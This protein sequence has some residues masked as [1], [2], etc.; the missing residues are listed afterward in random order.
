[1]ASHLVVGYSSDTSVY[2]EVDDEISS[3]LSVVGGSES[4]FSF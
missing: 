1:M 3:Y 4:N 2:I